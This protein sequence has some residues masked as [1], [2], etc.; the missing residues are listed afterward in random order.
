MK[1]K[2]LLT[3]DIYW[4]VLGAMF[5]MLLILFLV[6]LNRNAPTL[7]AL[8]AFESG[9]LNLAY[10]LWVDNESDWSPKVQRGYALMLLN[11]EYIAQ[12]F[13]LGK[14]L[15]IE[16]ANKC[17]SIAM[18]ELGLIFLKG[19]QVGQDFDLSYNW[20]IKA[21][22]TGDT[23]SMNVVGWMYTNGIGVNKDLNKA[24]FWYGVSALKGNQAAMDQLK[25][26]KV[27]F[28]P[29]EYAIVLQSLT[30]WEPKSVC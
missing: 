2:S 1:I 16:S 7:E 4:R 13:K 25:Y 9:E 20:L 28:K 12:D 18:R 8:A 15:L 10:H 22:Q 26:L 6:E 11:G 30:L 14:S 3:P 29:E 21:A 5:T 19:D 27:F 24:L 17:D 23:I